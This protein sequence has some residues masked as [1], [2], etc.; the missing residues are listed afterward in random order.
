MKLNSL[1]QCKIPK[2]LFHDI[3]SPFSCGM[4]TFKAFK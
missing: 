1:K 4:N 2:I 3:V